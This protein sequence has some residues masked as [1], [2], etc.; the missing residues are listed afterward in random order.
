[1]QTKDVS[2]GSTKK[3]WQE[4]STSIVTKLAAAAAAAPEPEQLHMRTQQH[5]DGSQDEQSQYD[6]SS[7]EPSLK[8]GLHRL[9]EQVCMWTCRHPPCTPVPQI[10]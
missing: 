10:V 4:Y 2:I 7:T 3:Q 8:A 9:A 5:R 6:E 1:M